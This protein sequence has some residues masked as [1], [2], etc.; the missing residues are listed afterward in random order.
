MAQ[1]PKSA[2]DA[3]REANDEARALENMM[4]RAWDAFAARKGPPVNE[5]LMKEVRDAR[6]RASDLL[7]IAMKLLK[8]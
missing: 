5:G 6:K 4:S 3:W 7:C 8:P 1:D 2:I